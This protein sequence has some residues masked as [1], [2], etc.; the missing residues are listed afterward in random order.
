MT[1]AAP[2]SSSDEGCE[3]ADDEEEGDDDEEEEEE[4]SARRR[5]G[6][7]GGGGDMSGAYSKEDTENFMRRCDLPVSHLHVICI[8]RTK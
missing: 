2:G 8:R 4:G 6:D 7:S 3:G 5:K 1:G